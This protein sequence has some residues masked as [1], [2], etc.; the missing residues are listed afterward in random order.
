MSLNN[1]NEKCAVCKAY[2]FEEDD[3]VYC[4]EC[5]APHH[6]DCYNFIG[7]CGLKE[8]HGTEDQY[9]KPEFTKQEENQ[10]PIQNNIVCGM[11]GEKYDVE[12][13]TCP[14]CRA[15][16]ISKMGGRFVAFD[17]LGGVPADTDLGDG[18]TANEAKRFVASN[19]HRYMPKFAY[20]KKGRKVSWNWLAFLTPCGWFMSRKMY[21]LGGIAGALQIALTLFTVPFAN[22]V[23]M[24][25]ASAVGNYIELSNLILENMSSIGSVAF[26]T[27]FVG[28]M[29]EIALRV[30]T[31]VFGDLIYRNHVIS[32][33]NE[34]KRDSNDIEFAFH[35]KGGI[36]IFAGLL[37]YFA[38]TY[39]PTII[40]TTLGIM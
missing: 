40:A 21:L 37:G 14:N 32:Q 6:R 2:L 7:H 3:I 16:N 9:K 29:L 8:L 13:T 20:F 30:I 24:L 36:S 38:V 11:C 28:S 5:G 25:D 19:T 22:A 26:L 15:P 12:E 18:V 23:S 31:A 39:V 1:A 17:F 35:K 33:V 10:D 34:I 27:A 4:P